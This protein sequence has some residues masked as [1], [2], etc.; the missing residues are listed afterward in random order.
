MAQQNRSPQELTK[1]D[2]TG[3]ESARV[4]FLRRERFR[5]YADLTC[6]LLS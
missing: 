1:T 2:L 4:E 6:A 3:G 5:S